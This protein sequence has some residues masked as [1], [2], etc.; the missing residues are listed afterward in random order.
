MKK[1]IFILTISAGTIAFT[2][3]GNKTAGEETSAGTEEKTAS[4]N[5]L[6]G[7]WE[8]VKTEGPLAEMNKGTQ[9]VFEGTDKLTMQQGSFKNPGKT[10]IT[11]TSFTWEA[12][13]MKMDYTYKMEGSQLVVE[14]VN[15]GGQKFWMDKK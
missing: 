1:L 2:A 11:D 14:V 12:N 5:K 10:A 15:S 9:Y 6:E 8:I 4:G 13:G 3:C 7:T